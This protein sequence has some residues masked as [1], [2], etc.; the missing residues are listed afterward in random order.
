MRRFGGSE[1][2]GSFVEGYILEGAYLL[3]IA[4]VSR[5]AV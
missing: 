2:Y 1:S 5:G 4:L 3:S